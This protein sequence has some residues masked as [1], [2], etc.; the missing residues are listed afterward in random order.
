MNTNTIHIQ[1]ARW[2][3]RLTGLMNTVARQSGLDTFDLGIDVEELYLAIKG[4]TSYLE[5]EIINTLMQKWLE[6]ERYELFSET[7]LSEDEAKKQQMYGFNEAKGINEYE[8]D[9]RLLLEEQDLMPI[10]RKKERRRNFVHFAIYAMCALFVLPFLIAFF[11][12]SSKTTNIDYKEFESDFSKFKKDYEYIKNFKVPTEIIVPDV[13]KINID[14]NYQKFIESQKQQ[15]Q[16]DSILKA[17]QSDDNLQKLLKMS[18]E[19]NRKTDIK[20]N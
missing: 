13:P 6:T 4:R 5:S 2:R 12:P 20:N 17:I 15:K 19:Q 16:L 18:K 9:I 8:L 14:S 1:S 3:G 7:V 10:C 11:V